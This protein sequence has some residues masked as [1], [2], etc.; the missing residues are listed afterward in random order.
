MNT[1]NLDGQVF[2]TNV[3]SLI[4]NAGVDVFNMGAVA[5]LSS[6]VDGMGGGDLIDYSAVQTSITTNLQS[7]SSTKTGGIRN[8]EQIV[9]SAAVDTLIL[10]NTGNTVEVTGASV[11][12][13]SSGLAFAGYEKHYWWQRRRQFQYW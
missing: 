10:N 11:G 5:S 4:G 6:I 8:I 7:G 2:F 12:S 3:E 1:G 13:L 9:G